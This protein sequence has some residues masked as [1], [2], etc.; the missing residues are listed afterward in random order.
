MG[1]LKT[2]WPH[3]ST[4]ARLII[5]HEAVLLYWE[6]GCGKTRA[7]IEAIVLGGFKLNL[8]IC[9]KPVCDVWVSEFQAHT[10]SPIRLLELNKG[11]IRNASLLADSE[12]SRSEKST[13][14]SVLIVNYERIHMADMQMVLL[15]PGF[16]WDLVVC[17]E[18]QKIKAPQGK[19]SKV[20]DKLGLRAHKRA[21][22][23]GTPMGHSPL[24]LFGQFRF[25]KRTIFG[26]WYMKFQN[27]YAEMGGYRVNGRPVQVKGF[28]N[29]PELREKFY[30]ITYRVRKR[31]V[32]AFTLP[33]RTDETRFVTLCAKTMGHY[34]ALEREFITEVEAG[35]VTAGNALTRL[36]RL[37]QMTSGFVRIEDDS[38]GQY[39]EISYE[40]RNALTSLLA[41][42]LADCP[43][44]VYC[45]FRK[46]L[47]SVKTVAKELNRPYYEQSGR[48]RHQWR[49]FQEADDNGILGAQIQSAGLGINLTRASNAV[50][51]SIGLSLTDYEQ[52][53]DRNHRPGQDRPVTYYHIIAEKTKD[54]E[55]YNALM[56]RKDVIATI[57]HNIDP[58]NQPCPKPQTSEE[59]TSDF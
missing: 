42:D 10:N 45:R 8:I 40:K 47:D 53:R 43:V 7:V 29:I 4:G 6:M 24:D 46:D 36:L 9:P 23:T 1:M 54:E 39:E 14:Q 5:D 50:Y 51:Y 2:S 33:P 35:I 11:P 21:E 28:K 20:A 56:D 13:D 44:I 17:D 25:L 22:T 48:T 41:F 26:T 49:E 30:S 27:R 32:S 15:G 38:T 55:T 18:G 58:E 52:S 3:Q 37:Q 34:R 16:T 57:L 12:I 19:T 59:V 31:D